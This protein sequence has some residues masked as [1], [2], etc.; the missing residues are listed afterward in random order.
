VAVRTL[1]GRGR[2]L[3]LDVLDAPVLT[4]AAG[5]LTLGLPLVFLH[6]A[7]QP[8]L[9]IHLG[10]VAPQ[11]DLSDLAVLASAAAALAAGVVHGFRPL[12]SGTP[13]WIAGAALL[14]MIVLATL[15]PLAGSRSYAW[16]THLVS[17]GKFVEYALLALAVP[18][19]VRRS[20]ELRLVLAGLVAW[21]CV[22]TAFA[23]GQFFGWSAAGAYPAGRR[24]PSFLG[25]HDFAALSGG[26]LAVALAALLVPGWRV[27][28]RLAVAAGLSGA[29]GI[30]ISGSSA[31]AIGLAAGTAAALLAAR[32]R[33]TLTL[34]TVAVAVAVVAAVGAAVVALRAGDFEQYLHRREATKQQNVETY[35]QHSLLAYIGL[36]IFLDHPAVGV[37]WQG[38]TEPSAYRPQ[39][40]AAHR[41]YPNAP[42]LAFP[43]VEHPWGI[44]NAYVQ[45]L[46]DLGVV[47]FVLFV[48]LY[49]TG[50]AAASVP[51]LRGPPQLAGPALA[52]AVWLLVT[53]GV[54]G[55][56]G[57]VA[58]IP[59][60]GAMWL[61]LG[62]A[63]AARAGPADAF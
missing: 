56:V 5:L 57:L 13:I 29:T 60:D 16:K 17:A 34:R 22:A 2:S 45:A 62:L 41:R 43:S 44:Q 19:A 50:L 52:A 8:T 31:G 6:I 35:V 27:D 63:A 12:R 32:L 39:L 4:T 46:A 20:R 15:Y 18:L 9:T 23:I 54:W 61:G 47:G 7:Y 51:V 36:R 24:Q 58:G 48:G 38:S 55:A 11:L 10:G 59:L 40:P 37:G 26:A 33:R 21:S 14:A 30:V 3:R 25:H 28:R 42:E 49:L 53:A 1:S